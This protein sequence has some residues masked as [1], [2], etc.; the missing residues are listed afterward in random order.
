M[1]SRGARSERPSPRSGAARSPARCRAV[2]CRRRRGVPRA[3]LEARDGQHL[4]GVLSPVSVVGQHLL[5]GLIDHERRAGVVGLVAEVPVERVAW[6]VIEDDAAGPVASAP[7]RWATSP[8]G[9]QPEGTVE[10]CRCSSERPVT[11]ALTAPTARRMSRPNSAS[12]A[13]TEGHTPFTRKPLRHAGT[14][15]QVLTQGR[16]RTNDRRTRP[17]HRGAPRQALTAGDMAA[18]GAQLWPARG[19]PIALL[20]PGRRGPG[21]RARRAPER[22]CTSTRDSPCR[23]PPPMGSD[24]DQLV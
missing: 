10:V 3:R 16:R 12:R 9:V 15:P 19:R 17:G 24:E 20:G 6:V 7:P 11:M 21:R 4:V 23:G 1:R 2:R 5:R 13:A 8:A 14:S 18:G 22:R